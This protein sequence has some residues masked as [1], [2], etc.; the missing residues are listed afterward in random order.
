MVRHQVYYSS[1]VGAGRYTWIVG[2]AG[3]NVLVAQIHGSLKDTDFF[4][5][6]SFTIL[7]L[8]RVYASSTMMFL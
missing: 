6:F 4:F 2:S 8:R 1:L 7:A 3:W 5:S